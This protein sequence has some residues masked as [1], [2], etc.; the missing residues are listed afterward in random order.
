MVASKL[1]LSNTVHIKSEYLE[2]TKTAFRSALESLNFS[3]ANA[4][5][6]IINSWCKEQTKKKIQSIVEPRM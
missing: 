3:D 2:L 1:F 6:E 4:A 5:A